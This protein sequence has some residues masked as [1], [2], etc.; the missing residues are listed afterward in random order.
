MSKR[1]LRQVCERHGVISV[2]SDVSLRACLWSYQ[3][4]GDNEWCRRKDNRGKHPG[5]AWQCGKVTIEQEY[6]G[7]RG[8]QGECELALQLTSYHLNSVFV[9][10]MPPPS[11]RHSLPAQSFP[12]CR[13]ASTRSALT[14]PSCMRILWPTALFD[15]AYVFVCACLSVHLCAKR[16]G[17]VNLVSWPLKDFIFV[18][19]LSDLC[20]LHARP[21]PAPSKWQRLMRVTSL[22]DGCPSWQGICSSK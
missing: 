12:T 11:T 14:G 1:H 21:V 5:A 10:L 6:M 4:P 2:E 3:Q 19:G 18:A 8:H 16:G 7:Q 13:A 22:S 15:F 9:C 17:G 20:C